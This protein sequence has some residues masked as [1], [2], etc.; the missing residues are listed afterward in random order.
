MDPDQCRSRYFKALVAGDQQAATDTVEKAIASRMTLADI[1]LQ[2]F[3]PALKR[4]GNLWAARK[5]NV[6]QEKLATQI[7]LAEMEKLRLIHGPRRRSPSC[8]L[9]C[10]VE[11]EQHFVGARMAADLFSTEGWGVDFLGA[12][13]PTKTLVEIIADRRPHVL[14]LSLTMKQGVKYARRVIQQVTRLNVRPKILLGGAVAQDALRMRGKQLDCAVA[15]DAVGGVLLARNLLQSEQAKPLL[16][17]Y[18]RDLGRRIREL[19]TTT[20]WTQQQLAEATRLTRTYLVSVEGGKQN[21]TMDV[22]L[23]VANALNVAPE[24]LLSRREDAA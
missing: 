16:H 7:T 14:A 8:I 6:A 4:I 13:V 20:G 19:R 23:R 15:G 18:L 3:A 5:I 9:V 21:V 10:C 17:E 24:R 22:L 11:G 2:V 1:Y 12:D